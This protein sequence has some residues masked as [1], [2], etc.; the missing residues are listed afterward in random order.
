MKS[1]ADLRSEGLLKPCPF[2]GGQARLKMHYKVKNSWYVQCNDCGVRTPYS[3]Q[4]AYEPWT[5][6]RDYP[7]KLWNGRVEDGN[8]N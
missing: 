5:R 6:A 4:A 8:N 7:V 2:C 3:T 1:K